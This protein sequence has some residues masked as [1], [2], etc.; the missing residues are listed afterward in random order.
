MRMPWQKRLQRPSLDS[1][2]IWKSSS[3]N[4]TMQAPPSQEASSHSCDRK[5]VT[6]LRTSER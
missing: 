3:P 6:T 1:I 2:V 4:S 5:V